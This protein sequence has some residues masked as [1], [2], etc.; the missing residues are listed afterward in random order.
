MLLRDDDLYVRRSLA[1][2]QLR[3]VDNALPNSVLV[4]AAFEGSVHCLFGVALDPE[5]ESVVLF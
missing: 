3:G 1:F 4:V 2:V 5:L